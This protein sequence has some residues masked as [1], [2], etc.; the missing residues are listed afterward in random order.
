MSVGLLSAVVLAAGKGTRM[1]A[2]LPKVLHP[3]AGRPLIGHVLK[4]TQDLGCE[5]TV[6]VLAP[7]METVENVAR[8]IDPELRIAIQD[9]PLGTGHA[10]AAAMGGLE[11]RGTVLVLFGDTPLLLEDTVRRLVAARELDRA[12]R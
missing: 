6:L 3:L 5:R 7:G 12:V 4:L 1:R 10:V 8:E 11:G 2:P 9:P